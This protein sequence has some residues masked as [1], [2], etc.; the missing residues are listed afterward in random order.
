M[1]SSASHGALPGERRRGEALF[2]VDSRG[3]VLVADLGDDPLTGAFLGPDIERVLASGGSFRTITRESL[4]D[5]V[6]SRAPD[7]LIAHTGRCG[8]T[9]AARGLE[10]AGGWL[11]LREPPLL[12]RW[13]ALDARDRASP[14]ELRGIG[15][16]FKALADERS[17]RLGLKLTS[18]ALASVGH[19][20]DAFPETP[21]VVL[22]R[23]PQKVASSVQHRPPPWF[24]TVST[25]VIARSRLAVAH[26][27]AG[28]A[29]TSASVAAALWATG[30][31]AALDLGARISWVTYP[32][33]VQNF[34]QITAEISS[35]GGLPLDADSIAATLTRT[36]RLDS[37]TGGKVVARPP[38]E[39]SA[40]NRVRTIT[41]PAMER[42]SAMGIDLAEPS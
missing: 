1:T 10:D 34:A 13:L 29:L 40:A 2:D 12:A 3:Q 6:P 15:S 28:G 19:I 5:L 41:R 42:L 24:D 39:K 35:K 37:K 23:D 11:A 32:Q 17:R 20:A 33:L 26:N 31:E 16:W 36:A 38:L 30:I 25:S 8:S 7:L 14:R 22:V 18:T 4:V 27:R 21:L 9:L